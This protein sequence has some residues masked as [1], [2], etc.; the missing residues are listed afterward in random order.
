[1]VKLAV[2]LALLVQESDSLLEKLEREITGVVQKVRPSVVAVTAK[3]SVRA[4]PDVNLTQTLSFSGIIYRRDGYIVTDAGGVA[5]AE[6][7]RVILSDGKIL[8][9]AIVGADGKTGIA[10]L[11]VEAKDLP[12]VPLNTSELQTGVF[13]IAV[14]NAY[15]MRGSAAIGTLGGLDRSIMVNGRKFEGMLQLTTPASPGDCG[16]LVADSRGRLIG[17]I[18]SSYSMEE[19]F[20]GFW[21]SAQSTVTFATPAE[22]VEFVADRIIK[23]K[24]MVRGWI[25]CSAKGCDEG[26]EILKI[27][28]GSPARKAGLRRGDVIVSFD[29]EAVK[30]VAALQKKIERFEEAKTVKLVYRRNGTDT[31]V[32]VKVEIER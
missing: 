13:A 14:G 8:K 28:T 9:A 17:I 16:G 26:A 18:H 24:K 4:E 31:E 7:I 30:D 1:M 19:D 23:H 12:A 25:G 29:G 21:G 10:V 11:K 15:G 5:D 2:L 3:F 22:T 20:E 6:E 27:E 32:E